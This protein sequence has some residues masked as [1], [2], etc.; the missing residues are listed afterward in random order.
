MVTNNEFPAIAPR[1]ILNE[2][3]RYYYLL[4]GVASIQDRASLGNE[5]HVGNE[6]YVC[7]D[8]CVCSMCS[9]VY[10]VA[11][12]SRTIREVVVPCKFIVFH[13]WGK[14]ESSGLSS[15]TE[16]DR[17]SIRK[18]GSFRRRLEFRVVLL[19]ERYFI[20]ELRI[21]V[22]QQRRNDYVFHVHVSFVNPAHFTSSP[23]VLFCEKHNLWVVM[24]RLYIVAP[25]ISVF[26]LSESS[27]NDCF[28]FRSMKRR[29]IV[30]LW[31][32]WLIVKCA[33]L[34]LEYKFSSRD[35]NVCVSL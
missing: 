31:K 30:T 22:L 27:C 25:R 33:W 4:Q 17:S 18:S 26:E 7:F 14:V 34:G 13:K 24:V 1:F 11:L 9:S 6:H 21:S 8:F 35:K 19:C 3:E 23:V 10:M 29:L 32:M 28:M 2:H 5:T 15:R 12:I 20:I 16:R